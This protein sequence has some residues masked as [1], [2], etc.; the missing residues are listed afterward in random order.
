MSDYLAPPTLASLRQ[1]HFDPKAAQQAVS[2]GW[3]AVSAL[4]KVVHQID[5]LMVIALAQSRYPDAEPDQAVALLLR[6]V[7][8]FSDAIEQHK[9][10][11]KAI[12]DAEKA[13]LA[14]AMSLAARRVFDISATV[15]LLQHRQERSADDIER[16]RKTLADARVPLADIDR[17]APV[18]DAA[19]TAAMAAE[20]QALQDE[21]AALEGFIATGNESLLPEG[22]LPGD[23]Q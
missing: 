7:T 13:R 6:D 14:P 17:L 15:K 3:Q 23:A 12:S 11:F 20:I 22:F 1:L 18:E 9:T 19:A 16:R 5:A 4:R 21:Q 10:Q 8:Q 2:D